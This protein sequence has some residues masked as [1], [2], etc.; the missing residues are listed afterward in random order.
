MKRLLV[1]VFVLA[2]VPM[3]LG[4]R[5]T[6]DYP[7]TSP[8]IAGVAPNMISSKN[9]LIPVSVPGNLVPPAYL[10]NLQKLGNVRAASA[11]IGS[12]NLNLNLE[13]NGQSLEFGTPWAYKSE[14]VNGEEVIT[15]IFAIPM[16][17]A[18][19]TTLNIDLANAT[20]VT[21]TATM[22]LGGNEVVVGVPDV[23]QQVIE[24]EVVEGT[25]S[26][27]E[28][29]RESEIVQVAQQVVNTMQRDTTTGEIS[30]NTGLEGTK[31]IM[32][33]EVT[34]NKTTGTI[35]VTP[36]I[37]KVTTTVPQQPSVIPAFVGF[38]TV[39][40]HPAAGGG[41]I[42]LALNSSTVVNARDVTFDKVTFKFYYVKASG[43]VDIGNIPATYSVIIMDM[44]NPA[45]PRRIVTLREDDEMLGG[46]KM[47][48]F[49]NDAN[50][51]TIDLSAGAGNLLEPGKTYR[52]HFSFPEIGAITKP[53]EGFFT[54]RTYI[55]QTLINLTTVK[56]SHYLTAGL[57]ELVRN[58]D[59]VGVTDFPVKGGK[60]ELTF[61]QALSAV[62]N[63]ASI[64]FRDDTD[65]IVAG[66]ALFGSGMSLDGA[67]LILP[68]PQNIGLHVGKTY[69]VFFEFGEFQV[70]EGTTVAVSAT[71]LFRVKTFQTEMVD[72]TGRTSTATANRVD[73]RLQNLEV[74]FNHELAQNPSGV[75]RV[76]RY[77]IGGDETKDG[78]YTYGLGATNNI[79]VDGKKL[80]I[81]TKDKELVPERRYVI[82]YEEG[83]LY[84]LDGFPVA[85]HEPIT[86]FTGPM[87]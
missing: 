55:P 51:L 56:A 40:N 53:F 41:S 83:T 74:S 36:V 79:T 23:K 78:E 64:M 16:T 3:F 62:P 22:N 27:D 72:W 67:K 33:F 46:Q 24:K 43:T 17:P 19:L 70:P 48:T 60:F 30:A 1:V 57:D 20:P 49:S 15:F 2:L 34:V 87:N 47:L 38:T 32:V 58:S 68:L 76:K 69:R 13:V 18:L 59:T 86:L 63:R 4:C 26:T 52:A 42:T 65:R 8:G 80:I 12:G 37:V 73:P 5:V 82:S 85:V 71:D 50:V 14:M 54:F 11:E 21:A 61:S 25:G 84:D 81:D 31:E 77:V 75:I 28:E 9:V 44:T 45:N 29:R 10:Q 7:P 35:T 6:G 66:A 39:T